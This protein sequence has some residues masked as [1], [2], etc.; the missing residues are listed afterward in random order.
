ML[1]K[2][3]TQAKVATY[4]RMFDIIHKTHKSLM[5]ARDVRNNHTSVAKNYY[6]I[7]ENDV[8]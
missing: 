1:C 2:K 3:T 6:G 5:H 4:E 7:T 8:R